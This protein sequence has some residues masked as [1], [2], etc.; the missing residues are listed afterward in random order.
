M[1]VGVINIIA[2]VAVLFYS[3]EMNVQLTSSL[4]N[5]NESLSSSLAILS[6][7]TALASSASTNIHI[8]SQNMSNVL[9]NFSI[10]LYAIQQNFNQEAG[11]FYNWSVLGYRPQTTQEIG[12]TFQ[13]LSTQIGSINNNDIPAMLH[14]VNT[15]TSNVAS[16]LSNITQEMTMLRYNLFTLLNTY[17][18]DIIQIQFVLTFVFIGLGIYTILQGILFITLGKIIL[19]LINKSKFK[20]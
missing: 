16:P 14:L 17:Q 6:N 10:N 20:K 13:T 15:E 11:F 2:G 4:V 18:S 8:L 5:I 12:N 7:A 9:G 3:Y 19:C 1:V